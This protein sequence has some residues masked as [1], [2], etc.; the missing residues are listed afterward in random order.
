MS[1][2]IN[3]GIWMNHSKSHLIELTTEIK[4]QTIISAF[5]NRVQERTQVKS[6]QMMHGKEHYLQN[7]YYQKICDEIKKYQKVMLFGPT[8]AKEELFHMI[9]ADHNC[10]HIRVE[11]L[12][13]EKLKEQEQLAFV[14]EYFAT[15]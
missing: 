3:L 4:S 15:H 2:I 12:V 13:V 7:D 6:E 1:T 14:R 8:D 5:A 10:A 9:K 11:V